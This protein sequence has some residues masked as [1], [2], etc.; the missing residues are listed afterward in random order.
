VDRITQFYRL[1]QAQDTINNEDR[2]YKRLTVS[3]E[4]AEA[5]EE[6]QRMAA[7]QV[8]QARQDEFKARNRWLTA[9]TDYA[10]RL[11]QFKLDLGLPPELNI[12]PIARIRLTA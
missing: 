3:R 1:L 5:L 2:A 7:Y 10:I 12:Q 6:A 8:D 4:R 11:D 9:R